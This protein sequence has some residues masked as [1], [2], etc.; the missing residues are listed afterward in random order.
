MVPVLIFLLVCVALLIYLFKLEKNMS[1]KIENLDVEL[2]SYDYDTIVRNIDKVSKYSTMSLNHMLFNI[3]IPLL[4]LLIVS[5]I[6]E[7]VRVILL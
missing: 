7:L 2:S 5:A 3:W 4:V 1:Q 6:I